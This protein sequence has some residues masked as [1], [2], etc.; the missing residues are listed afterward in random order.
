MVALYGYIDLEI[1]LPFCRKWFFFY[2]ILI[3]LNFKRYYTCV[4]WPR[5]APTMGRKSRLLH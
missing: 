3:K 1:D 5:S 4:E 2:F